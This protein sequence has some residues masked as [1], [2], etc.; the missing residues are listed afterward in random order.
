MNT[1]ISLKY[2]AISGLLIVSTWFVGYFLG[3]G[4]LHFAGSEIL[5]YAV[6]LL[7]LTAVFMGIKNKRDTGSEKS[8]TFKE[9][10]LTGLGIVIVASVIYV[11][12]WM[13]YM[14][15]FA[16]D[17]V[18]KYAA[19]QIELIENSEVSD[20]EK[21]K[22]I[23]EMNAFIEN[24]RKPYVMA[25]FVFIEIFPVGVLVTLISAL[26]LKRKE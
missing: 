3:G 24:Y 17:F 18:D 10:F 9:G 13:L 19:S 7:A 21:L 5:G 22:Q 16:P 11:A 14:P 12:G 23:E 4:D 20:T 26:V 2:G 8:F 1:K 15:T 6:M 25:S